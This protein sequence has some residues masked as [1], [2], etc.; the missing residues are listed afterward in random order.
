L[1]DG[2]GSLAGLVIEEFGMGEAEHHKMEM[3]RELQD[4]SQ[5]WI[6]PTCGRR[7]I[8]QWPPFY[9]RVVLD[10]GDESA[11]HSGAEGG[12]QMG[13]AD[14]QHEHEHPAASLDLPLAEEEDAFDPYLAPFL[15]WLDEE[16]PFKH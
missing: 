8:M 10:A 1:N 9:Q 5:E 7:M 13:A 4:G 2:W 3:V 6:C 16:D 11:V 12:L 14:L 15:A